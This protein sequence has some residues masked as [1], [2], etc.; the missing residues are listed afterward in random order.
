MSG[1][2]RPPDRV[3]HDAASSCDSINNIISYCELELTSEVN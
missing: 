2:V 1:L 3:S